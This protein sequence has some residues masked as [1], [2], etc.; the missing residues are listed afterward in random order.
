[1]DFVRFFSFN[2]KQKIQKGFNLPIL[3]AQINYLNNKTK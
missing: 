3:K 2:L 1:M